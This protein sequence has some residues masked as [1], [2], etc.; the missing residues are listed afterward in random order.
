MISEIVHTILNST[1]DDIRQRMVA[2]KENAT[3]RTSASFQVVEEEGHIRLISK[4]ADI[5]PLET[6]EVGRGSGRRPPIAPLVEWAEAKFKFVGKEAQAVAW[7]VATKIG[8]QGTERHT[9]NVDIYSTPIEN[10]TKEL[11]ETISVRI[12]EQVK[13][14]INK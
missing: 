7:A 4:G 5:A 3:G 2:E 1:A 12:I 8:N 14:L 13:S 9:S 11:Q 10:A 6:L